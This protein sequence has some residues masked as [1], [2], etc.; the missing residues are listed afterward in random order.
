M[1]IV[2]W[3]QDAA[4]YLQP[5][6]RAGDFAAQLAA[7]ADTRAWDE[8]QQRQDQID[9]SQR[10]TQQRIT[11]GNALRAADL[12]DRQRIA[13]D[14][15]AQNKE[16]AGARNDTTLK[17]V[18]LRGDQQQQLQ[19]RQDQRLENNA[20]NR[21]K[22]ADHVSQLHQKEQ[23]AAAAGRYDVAHELQQEREHAQQ[24]AVKANQ[25]FQEQQQRRA[26]IHQQLMQQDRLQHS[27]AAAADKIAFDRQ[28]KLHQSKLET[29]DKQINQLQKQSATAI[30][31]AHVRV[32]Q[33]I[34]QKMNEYTAAAD[35]YQTFLGGGGATA[36]PAPAAA[37]G[38]APAAATPAAAD[39]GVPLT[40]EDA[41]MYLDLAGGDKE[42]ARDMAREAGRTF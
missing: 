8:Q 27:R 25:A 33:A 40:P 7:S 19:D 5:A 16:L 13:Q 9:E 26:Q 39:A 14:R 21:Q 12:V 6:A 34:E 41:K 20:L 30:G 11:E 24:E 18:S 22:L 29:L 36:Q 1:P 35:A 10:L 2:V 23:A 37:P 42:M 3:H 38:G 28:Q 32:E 4:P 15:L 31:D 17:A